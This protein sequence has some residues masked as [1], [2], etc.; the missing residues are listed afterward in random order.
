MGWNGKQDDPA[1]ANL[2]WAS[3]PIS[4][5]HSDLKPAVQRSHVNTDFLC[6]QSDPA[7]RILQYLDHDPDDDYDDPEDVQKNDNDERNGNDD[8]DDR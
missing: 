3:T 7:V 4:S 6:Q 5:Q 1:T 2:R 8:N